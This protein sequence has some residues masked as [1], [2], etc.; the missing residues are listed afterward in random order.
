MPTRNYTMLRL[1]SCRLLVDSP[2]V[3][4]LGLLQE[5]APNGRPGEWHD[6]QGRPIVAFDAALH[7]D[8]ARRDWPRYVMLH[9][10]RGGFGI[11]CDEA[12]PLH[13]SR[14]RLHALPR[15]ARGVHSPVQALARIA[16]AGETDLAFYVSLSALARLHPGLK[17][18]AG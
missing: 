18:V 16:V 12:M 11:A 6:A 5:A 9:G 4:G 1:A 14:V 8:T 7:A 15:L 2:A 13:E 10:G 3:L 17:A